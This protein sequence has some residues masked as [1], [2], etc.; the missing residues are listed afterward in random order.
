MR[1]VREPSLQ[2]PAGKGSWVT[3]E[4]SSAATHVPS[5]PTITHGKSSQLPFL[6]IP[7][8]VILSTIQS[9]PTAQEAHHVQIS[10][11]GGNSRRDLEF[12]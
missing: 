10:A 9:H 4:V 5:L 1:R 2:A 8:S 3:G 12:E 7:Y 11:A 6:P